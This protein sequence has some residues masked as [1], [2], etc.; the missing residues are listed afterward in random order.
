MG[1]QCLDAERLR[2]VMPAVEN[3]QTQ[4]LSHTISPMRPFAGDKGINALIGGLLQFV[5]RPPLTTPMRRQ[6]GGPPGI[7][8]GFAPVARCR[9]L[10]RS[11]R[12]ILAWA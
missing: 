1:R 2:R 4:L 10:T 6:I 7:T 8:R 3:I 9:R 5:P 11:A 12:E